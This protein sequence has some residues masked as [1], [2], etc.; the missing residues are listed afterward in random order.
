MNLVDSLVLTLS[1]PED[2]LLKQKGCLNMISTGSPRWMNPRNHWVLLHT[3][4]ITP[5]FKQRVIYHIFAKCKL[6][7]LPTLTPIFLRTLP[8]HYYYSVTILSYASNSASTPLFIPFDSLYSIYLY[9]HPCPFYVSLFWDSFCHTSP[10]R[11]F[12]LPFHFLL[13]WHSLSFFRST[14]STHLR[15]SI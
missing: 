7:H 3:L 12:I 13:L 4:G 1:L 11:K 8:F 15:A 10:Y 2:K 9:P 6:L 14:V 5:Y